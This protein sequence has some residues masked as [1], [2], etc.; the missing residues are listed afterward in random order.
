[1]SSAPSTIFSS[2]ELASLESFFNATNGPFWHW[3]TPYHEYGNPWN[4]SDQNINPCSS[5]WQGLSCDF[6][7]TT[8]LR[9]SLSSHYLDGSIPV[10][11]SNLRNITYIDL[12]FNNISSSIPC[13]ISDLRFIEYLSLKRNSLNGTLSYNL[14]WNMKNLST[15]NFA[16]NQ[17]TGTIPMNFFSSSCSNDSWYSNSTITMLAFSYNKFKGDIPSSIS[18]LS[19][20]TSIY[21]QDNSFDGMFPSVFQDLTLLRTLNLSS[22]LFTGVIPPNIFKNMS[23]LRNILFDTNFFSGSLPSSLANLSAL[24][25]ISAYENKFSGNMPEKFGYLPYLKVF[26]FDSNLFTGSI[27]Y[28][29]GNLTSMIEMTLY[30]CYFSNSLPTS[31]HRMSDLNILIAGQNYFDGSLDGVLNVNSLTTF[32]LSFNF[33]SGSIPSGLFGSRL[34]YISLV[35]NCFSGSI[36]RDLC[37]C[38]DLIHVAFDGLTSNC[39]SKFWPWPNS[40]YYIYPIEGSLPECIWSSLPKL[41]ILHASGNGL[42]GSIPSLPSYGS[43]TAVDLSFNRLGGSIPITLQRWKPMKYIS[44]SNNKIDGDITSIGNLS[45]VDST[46]DSFLGT[47][48][49]LFDNRLSGGIP[50]SLRNAENINILSGNI[51]QCS[52]SDPAPQ[53]DP[54][55]ADYVCGSNLLDIS[56]VCLVSA[57]GMLVLLYC[58]H[59]LTT[60]IKKSNTWFMSRMI[61]SINKF[62]IDVFRWDGIVERVVQE[63][64]NSLKGN[65]DGGVLAKQGFV[66]PHLSNFIII[67]R[68]LRNTASILGFCAIVVE[69]PMFLS[70]KSKYKTYLFQY[71]WNISMSFLSGVVPAVVILLYWVCFL[72]LFIIML[73]RLLC[74]YHIY[75]F[76]DDKARQP[77][78]VVSLTFD[79]LFGKWLSW[80]S[81]MKRFCNCSCNQFSEKRRKAICMSVLFWFGNFVIVS[82]LKG[83]FIF[84]LISNQS[85]LSFK[86][87]LEL[88]LSLFDISWNMLIIPFFIRKLPSVKSLTRLTVLKLSLL[89]YNMIVIPCLAVIFTD[90]SCFKGL[91]YTSS[92]VVEE[93]VYSDCSVYVPGT[94]S[95][96]ASCAQYNSW[97]YEYQYRP[98]FFY[99]FD[100]YS[101]VLVTYIPILMLTYCMLIGVV[102]FLTIIL[103]SKH[104]GDFIHK[105]FPG[106]Y[107]PVDYFAHRKASAADSERATEAASPIDRNT[108]FVETFSSRLAT[109]LQIR[110][111]RN[112]LNPDVIISSLMEHTLVLLTFGLAYPPLA[113]AIVVYICLSVTKWQVLIG[114]YLEQSPDCNLPG[115]GQHMGRQSDMVTYVNNNVYSQ[116]SPS[117]NDHSGGLDPICSDLGNAVHRCMWLVIFGSSI[118]FACIVLD[119]AADENGLYNSMWAPFIVILI[120]WILVVIVLGVT[121]NKDIWSLKF[122][123]RSNSKPSNVGEIPLHDMNEL[124][125]MMVTN[126]MH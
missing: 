34:K 118:F 24:I 110:L 106:I 3:L 115:V 72:V 117:E 108:N 105:F 35:E 4:F 8:V 113:F 5:S 94:S 93:F 32:D 57:S 70:L 14:I 121:M 49:T 28:S 116:H 90:S 53:N 45:F 83:G 39:A 76:V 48:L 124:N 123:I 99:N 65:V 2:I 96:N 102:P 68:T 6:D 55:S 109:M 77:S 52:K 19:S 10:D 69:F 111:T 88:L 58:L 75:L 29:F 1:M 78:T 82:I 60:D 30:G 62:F 59:A 114:R 43:L 100:C 26:S 51:F 122:I 89:F 119:I 18:C 22:N 84:L 103:I 87:L 11:F 47:T 85:N 37:Y 125:D 38:P 97:S 74:E 56:L 66:I 107:W 112:P 64:L 92:A 40:P 80:D 91:F 46:H 67:I 44:L 21:L 25:F 54:N 7:N 36:P 17:L 73:R 15:L 86:I 20:L 41:S 27:P 126:A 71:R 61:T 104:R 79:S 31:F 98:P 81:F 9:M 33:F 13:E 95:A 63:S 50:S 42:T 23:G 101:S 12:S 16:Y 120:P